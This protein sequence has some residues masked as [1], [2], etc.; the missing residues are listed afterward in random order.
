MVD[1]AY[2]VR[3]EKENQNNQGGDHEHNTDTQGLEGQEHNT[4]TQFGN[5]PYE[6]HMSTRR[7]VVGRISCQAVVHTTGRLWSS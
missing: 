5:D 1:H 7:S 3:V 4:H 2:Q 6:Q